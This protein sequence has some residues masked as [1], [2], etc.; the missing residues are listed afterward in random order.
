MASAA[1]SDFALLPGGRCLPASPAQQAEKSRLRHL[2]Q[3]PPAGA[4]AAG[5][6]E[7]TALDGGTA[8]SLVALNAEAKAVF[9]QL[10]RSRVGDRAEPAP[11]AK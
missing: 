10:A 1:C 3:R 5:E 8:F 7:L 6:L 9:E 2:R 4:A 11:T